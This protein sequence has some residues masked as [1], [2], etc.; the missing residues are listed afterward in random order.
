MGSLNQRT[1]VTTNSLRHNKSIIGW[2]T[3][4]HMRTFNIVVFP[5]YMALQLKGLEIICII[6]I[7]QYKLRSCTIYAIYTTI[8]NTL[9]HSALLGNGIEKVYCAWNIYQMDIHDEH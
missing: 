2:E 6:F 5:E 3:Y 9:L 8:P 7:T 1:K 4:V